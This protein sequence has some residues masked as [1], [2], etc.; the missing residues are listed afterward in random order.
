MTI[1]LNEYVSGVAE[2]E[3]DHWDVLESSCHEAA[4]VWPPA[5]SATRSW[6]AAT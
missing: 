2:C 3:Y 6:Y 1:E 5:A 4:R